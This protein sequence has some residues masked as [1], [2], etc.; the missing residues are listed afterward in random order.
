MS[1]AMWDNS[2]PGGEF[3]IE[4]AGKT[5]SL[6]ENRN[7]GGLRSDIPTKVVSKVRKPFENFYARLFSKSKID[8][9]LYAQ[10]KTEQY[11]ITF[12]LPLQEC[13]LTFITIGKSYFT[14]RL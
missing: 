11:Q 9:E 2:S 4:G 7:G 13:R 8:F 10:P 14:W 1:D 6:D 5:F 12:E 3:L